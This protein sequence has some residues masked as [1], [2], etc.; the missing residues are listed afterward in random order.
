M[1]SLLLVCDVSGS[2]VEGGKRLTLRG[3]TRQVEQY[4]RLGYGRERDLQ[5]VLWAD[6]AAIHPWDPSD[7]LPVEI[8]N[9]AGSA[10]W[11]ALSDLLGTPED[12]KILILTDGFWPNETHQ[13]IKDWKQRLPNDSLRIVRVGAD[14]NQ[15]LRGTD[16]F[17]SEAFLSAMEGWLEE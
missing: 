7:E 2:M 8:F 14:A 16:V 11:G 5:L 15:R 10:S 4:F 13:S 17:E 3:L 1:G 12:T 6:E 9:C